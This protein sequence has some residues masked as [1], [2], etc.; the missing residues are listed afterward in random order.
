M[1]YCID[2][3]FCIQKDV[4]IIEIDYHVFKVV[5]VESTLGVPA[6]CRIPGRLLVAP[7]AFETMQR[8]ALPMSQSVVAGV[9]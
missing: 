5:R 8:Y 1:L 7:K 3:F 2:C 9:V 6:E 4:I